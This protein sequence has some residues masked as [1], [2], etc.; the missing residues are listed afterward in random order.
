MIFL[1][2]ELSP[3]GIIDPFHRD[4]WELKLM[5]EKLEEVINRG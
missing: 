1:Q 3:E 2:S 4:G 5:V